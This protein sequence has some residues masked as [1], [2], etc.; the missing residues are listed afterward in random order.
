MS[1]RALAQRLLR[2]A[3]AI[4]LPQFACPLARAH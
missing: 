2:V 1:D 3:E 4:A